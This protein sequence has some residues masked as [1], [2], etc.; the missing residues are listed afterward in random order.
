MHQKPHRVTERNS[1]KEEVENFKNELSI[2]DGAVG[3]SWLLV[4]EIDADQLKFIVNIEDV[5]FSEA[6]LLV[7]NKLLFVENEVNLKN[8]LKL[9]VQTVR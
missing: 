6:Y 8:I 7:R 9:A 2:F 5:L 3:F 1:T 4:D